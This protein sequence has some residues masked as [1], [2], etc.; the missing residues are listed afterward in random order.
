MVN[1]E[2][3]KPGRR[4]VIIGS[5]HVSFSS[6]MTL[7][8]AGMVEEDDHYQTYA[9]PAKL[10]SAWWDFPIYRQ[11]G[12][13][14]IVG[15]KRVQ[16]VELENRATGEVFRLDCDTVVVTGWFRLDSALI[17]KGVLQEDPATTGPV[18]DLHYETSV[19]NVFAAG[20]VLRGAST[21][22]LCAMEGRYTAQ[23]IVR[24]S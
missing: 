22:D 20:N 15:D 3:L 1:L 18:V 8:H 11:R 14:R 16:G 9:L 19:R 23:N 7:K 24:R 21:H 6:A 4:A 10:L 13:N 5:E 17:F 12:V 2:R